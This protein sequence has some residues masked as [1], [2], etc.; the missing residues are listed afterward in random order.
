MKEIVAVVQ[1]GL[2]SIDKLTSFRVQ[3]QWKVRNNSLDSFSTICLFDIGELVSLPG[4]L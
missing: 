2:H 4:P 1:M 3:K